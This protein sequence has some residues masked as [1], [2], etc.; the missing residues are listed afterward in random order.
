MTRF[1]AIILA[2]AVLLVMVVSALAYSYHIKREKLT[3]TFARVQLGESKETVVQILGQPDEVENCSGS[4]SNQELTKRCVET[5]WYMS[6]LERWGFS[7][8]QDGKVIDKT[9]NVSF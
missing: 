2:A 4:D 5:Y 1:K 6:F 8:N 9:H 7:L 3:S